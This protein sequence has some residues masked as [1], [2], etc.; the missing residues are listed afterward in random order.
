[1]TKQEAYD[2]LG[3]L[4]LSDESIETRAVVMALVCILLGWTQKEFQA[5]LEGVQMVRTIEKLK[6]L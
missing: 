1:M 4:D 5:A 6:S 3:Q 2:A